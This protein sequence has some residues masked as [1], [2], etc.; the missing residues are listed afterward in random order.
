MSHS[1]G[2]AALTA[3]TVL[4]REKKKRRA[5]MSQPPFAGL[6]III[7]PLTEP[8]TAA[9]CSP[10]FIQEAATALGWA[11]CSGNG[12]DDLARV[13]WRKR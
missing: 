12:H 3:H 10:C 11:Y 9:S 5:V 6:L 1:P 13:E 8:A 2:L 7:S 4:C